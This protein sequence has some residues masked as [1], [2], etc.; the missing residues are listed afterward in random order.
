M[1]E[2]DAGRHGVAFV[3]VP[4]EVAF[5]GTGLMVSRATNDPRTSNTETVALELT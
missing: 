1:N 2:I 5:S 4:D 3:G